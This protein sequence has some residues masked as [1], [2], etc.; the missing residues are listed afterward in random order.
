MADIVVVIADHT[1]NDGLIFVEERTGIIIGIRIAVGIGIDN[2]IVIRNQGQ[3]DGHLPFVDTGYAVDAGDD[4]TQRL[5]DRT[6]MKLGI[7]AS[8]GHR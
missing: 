3:A 2:Q 7:L 6:T 4:G 5:V 1:V 8:G